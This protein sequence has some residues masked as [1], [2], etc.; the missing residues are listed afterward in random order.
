LHDAIR[1][2]RASSLLLPA[3][4]TP[5][6]RRNLAPQ[7]TRS[8]MEHPTYFVAAVLVM[9]LVPG[10]TNTLLAAAGASAG[11]S[12]SLP[13]LLG[14]VA[15]YDIAIAVARNILSP[16]IARYALIPAALR[17]AAATYLAALAIKLWR[18]Q[19]TVDRAPVTLRRV[20][21]TTLLNPKALIVGLVLMPR[22]GQNILPYFG[23]FTAL[24]PLIAICWVCAGSM[25]VR[26]NAEKYSAKVPRVASIALSFFAAA[27]I[28]STMR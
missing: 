16:A 25:L 7:L 5:I 20:F 28:V 9:L 11:I 3:R 15:G 23:A 12:R 6:L 10:P 24:V 13:L 8:R 26:A 21:V 18:V 22:G 4:G 27:L 17:I 14:E 2:V 19:W 1:R